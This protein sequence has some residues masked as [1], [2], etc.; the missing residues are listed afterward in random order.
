MVGTESKE[1]PKSQ[2][3]S[4]LAGAV[5]GQLAELV[6]SQL[7]QAFQDQDIDFTNP[8]RKKKTP[9]LSHTIKDHTL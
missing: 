5:A 8:T 2:P 7:K 3:R 1:T 9:T 4:P 6:D